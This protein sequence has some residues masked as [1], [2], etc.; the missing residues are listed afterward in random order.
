MV[1]QAHKLGMAGIGIAD[2]NSVAGVVRAWSGLKKA[3]EELPGE[4]TL[5]LA[6]GA[7]LVFMDGT[8]DI[9]A[10]PATRHGWGRLTR[11]LSTGNLRAKRDDLKGKKGVC[12]LY[13]DDLMA[14]LDELLLIVM[15]G[16]KDATSILLQ[17]LVAAA[18][19]R[20]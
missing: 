16:E 8:P 20:V 3:K 14:H 1:E 6:T 10:Y 18:P 11:L 2:W 17:R 19:G 13:L 5:R 7:R 15:P 4:V 9:I 12:E